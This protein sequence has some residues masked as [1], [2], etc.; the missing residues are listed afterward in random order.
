MI[1][2]YWPAWFRRLYSETNQWPRSYCCI[3]TETTGFSFDR[4]VITEWGHCLVENN[5]VIDQLSLVINWTDRNVPPNYWLENKLSQVRQSLALKGKTYHIDS[6]VMRSKGM[7]PEKA[8]EFIQ[9][10]TTTIINRG[11]PIVAH[12][13]NFDEKMLAGNFLQFKF[14]NGYTFGTNII[15]TMCIEKASQIPDNPKAHPQK[16]DTL[17]TYFDRVRYMRVSGITASMDDHC[18]AKYK[19]A[20]KYGL[21]LRDMHG[22]KT[23]S[24]CCHLLMQEFAAQ[25]TDP[26]NPPI[27]PTADT[28]AARTGSTIT[29]RP[30]SQVI[31]KRIRGQR[32]S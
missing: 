25:I 6:D 14:G 23:D 2:N 4:D 8:F 27:Y 1:V 12:N 3:D 31:T 13:G 10:F 7:S 21:S 16:N 11:I 29:P 26:I 15:D 9:K 32:N 17:R 5:Q 22:A 18:F 24:Y 19:F 20:E 30:Q 28:K